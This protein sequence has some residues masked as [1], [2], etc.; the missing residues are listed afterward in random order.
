MSSLFYD[1][2]SDVMS[3]IEKD[4]KQWSSQPDSQLLSLFSPVNCFV[5]LNFGK[6]GR[7]DGMYVK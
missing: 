4:K 5:L 1:L 3:G 2:S 6:Y 7:T